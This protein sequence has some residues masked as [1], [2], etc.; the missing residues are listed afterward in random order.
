MKLSNKFIIKQIKGFLRLTDF[1]INFRLN[2]NTFN[3]IDEVKKNIFKSKDF[4]DI[5]YV[6]QQIQNLLSK[7]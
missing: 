5:N 4:S 6:H 3:N 7:K 1:Y 2:K